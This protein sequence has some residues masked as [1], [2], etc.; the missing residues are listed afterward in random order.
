MAKAK[1]SLDFDVIS[2][3]SGVDLAKILGCKRQQINYFVDIE[4]PKK[5]NG[6]YSLV[7]FLQ[8][9]INHLKTGESED[10]KELDKQKRAQEIEKLKFFN[11]EKRRELVPAESVD[12]IL[13]ERAR[14]LSSFLPR[15]LLENASVMAMRPVDELQPILREVATQAMETYTGQRKGG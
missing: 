13:T 10:M 15:A 7:E 3:I 2:D 1:G 4:A 8:W 5:T 9:Y 6:R 12:E 14:S 11:A